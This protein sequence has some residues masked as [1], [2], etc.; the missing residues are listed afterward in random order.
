MPNELVNKREVRDVREI[1]ELLEVPRDGARV[2]VE[3]R[4]AARVCVARG[5]H[6]RAS[7]LACRGRCEPADVTRHAQHEAVHRMPA[8]PRHRTLGRHS[9]GGQVMLDENGPL[10]ADL[11]ADGTVCSDCGSAIL[12]DGLPEQ[13]SGLP[14]RCNGCE[15]RSTM[16]A[17][18][19]RKRH[20]KKPDRSPGRA[21]R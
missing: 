9:R 19:R 15:K 21:S 17:R 16:A 7:W 10:L 8:L 6:A 12:A 2:P 18:R 13:G 4:R 3:Q 1:R 14:R 5:S 20:H 11:I